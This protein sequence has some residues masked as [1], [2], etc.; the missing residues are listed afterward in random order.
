MKIII[1][2]GLSLMINTLAYCQSPF[3]GNLFGPGYFAGSVPSTTMLGDASVI[4]A[5]GEF[6]LNQSEANINNQTAYSMFLNNQLLHTRVFFEKRQ[7][8][9][10]YRDLEQWQKQARKDLKAAGIYDRD[11]IE[12]LYGIHR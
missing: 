6:L 5:S 1:A 8:N 11:A 2:V 9:G 4:S 12:Y 7:I 3:I 10:Y